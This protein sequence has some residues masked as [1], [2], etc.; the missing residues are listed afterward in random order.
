M[1]FRLSRRTVSAA[2]TL[3]VTAALAV[4]AAGPATARA[5]PTEQGARTQ[6]AALVAQL[7]DLSGRERADVRRALVTSLH[8]ERGAHASAPDERAGLGQAISALAR[9]LRDADTQVERAAI[10]TS[11]HAL[12][13]QKRAAHATARQL[14]QLRSDNAALQRAVLAVTDTRAERRAIT[15]SFR[16]VHESFTCAS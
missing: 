4:G 16:H 1:T 7:H 13:A 11:I 15:A 14:R 6:V 8:T 5:C 9:T 10:V 3:A 2:T 12:Q